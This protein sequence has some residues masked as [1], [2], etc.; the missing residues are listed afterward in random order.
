MMLS[1]RKGDRVAGGHVL[2]RGL[3]LLLG[4]G[5]HIHVDPEAKADADE[6]QDDD[7]TQMRGTLTP[8]ERRAI[9]FVFR[10]KPPKMSSTAVRNPT[11]W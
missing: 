5:S 6:R 7:G 10:R 2:N 1:L 8:F 11:G 3:H 4:F 9:K